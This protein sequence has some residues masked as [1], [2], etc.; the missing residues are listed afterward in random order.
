VTLKIASSLDGGIAT[1]S[2]DSKWITGET[3]RREAHRLRAAHDA[4][5]VGA[6][7]V[8]ADDPGLTVRHVRGPN[9]VRIVLDP[10]LAT[11]PTAR[12]LAADGARRILVTAAGASA[13]ATRAYAALGAEVW[14]LPADGTGIRLDLLLDK[15]AAAGILS[16]LVEGGGRLA[17]SFLAGR[18][19]DRV[20]IFTAPVLLGGDSLGWT[21]GLLVDR[22][23]AAPRLTNVKMRRFGDDWQ[24]EGDV[25]RE[26]AG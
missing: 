11:P 16:L 8:I 20:R 10:E 24:I 2:G 5:L 17:G 3:A 18:F 1:R 22:V 9:P 7:T 4:V 14:T 25:E 26:V 19:V 13:A 15:A 6:G 12:W 23:A 21:G